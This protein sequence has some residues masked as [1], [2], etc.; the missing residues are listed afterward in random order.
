M[1]TDSMVRSRCI[2]YT[3]MNEEVEFETVKECPH[4]CKFK[5]C[6]NFPLGVMLS[7]FK[8][9]KYSRPRAYLEHS[10]NGSI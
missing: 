9:A 1:H 7:V 2:K 10:Y 8:T 5:L 4:E 6:I 3:L